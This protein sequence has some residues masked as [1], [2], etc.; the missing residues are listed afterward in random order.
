MTIEEQKAELRKQI[1]Q[2]KQNISEDIKI[3]EAKDV[4]AALE[5]MQ[6]FR[7]AKTILCYW[8]LP[9]ELNTH[10]FVNKWLGKKKVYLPRVEGKE[11]KVIEYKGKD[12]LHKGS[13]GISEPIGIELTDLSLIDLIIV[14]GIAFTKN[15]IRMGRGG[16]YYDK[17]LVKMHSAFTVGVGYSFQLKE[18]IP[19]LPHDIKLNRIITP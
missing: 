11:V 8:S 5:K 6:E 10:A 3:R 15:G 14:P 4:F 9:D 16:G 7:L 18:E 12:S 19:V 13:F 1:K 2:E 17:L